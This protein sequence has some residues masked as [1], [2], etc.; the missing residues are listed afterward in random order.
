MKTFLSSLVLFGAL[1]SIGLAADKAPIGSWQL[2]TSTQLQMTTTTGKK[3]TSAPLKGYEFATFSSDGSYISSEWLNQISI[4]FFENQ[5]PSYYLPL[6][7]FGQWENKTSS[8]YTVSY[9]KFVLGSTD[10]NTKNINATF[11]DRIGINPLLAKSFGGSPTIDSVQIVSYSDSGTAVAGKSV[12]GTK[13]M[14]LNASWKNNNSPVVTSITLTETYT[15][16]PAIVSTCCGTDIAKNST[17][18]TAFMTSIS[19]SKLQGVNTTASGLK[20]V[21]LQDNPNGTTP[22]AT[23]DTVTVNYR[24]FLP[25]GKVF[26][27]NSAISFKLNG[28]IAGWTE[29]LQLMK[30][31]AKYRFFIP[32]NLAYGTTG[33]SSIP[34]NSALVFDVELL[35]VVAATPSTTTS[36]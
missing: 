13:K 29:G 1:N 20:Y 5:K 24:G 28:V 34:G 4:L 35:D 15:G 7:V 33:N 12:K 25:S 14:V 6:S 8:S 18:S 21:I 27:S 36:P 11:F 17:D 9:D 16:K 30:K 2:T 10:K 32:S 31:G 26:D 22:T 19:N 3:V 23:T